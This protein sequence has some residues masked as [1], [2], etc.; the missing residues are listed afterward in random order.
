MHSTPSPSC[1]GY[2]QRPNSVRCQRFHCIF[3]QL[4]LIQQVRG[5]SYQVSAKFPAQLLYIVKTQKLSLKATQAAKKTHFS[6]FFI[7]FVW[8]T[9]VHMHFSVIPFAYLSVYLRKGT[10]LYIANLLYALRICLCWLKVQLFAIKQE[11]FKL[12][13]PKKC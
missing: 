9:V 12:A 11:F 2:K 6:L 10:V 13:P 5:Q 8:E 4:F 7:M 3:V 1:S